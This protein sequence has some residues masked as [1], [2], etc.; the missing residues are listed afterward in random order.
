MIQNA[1]AGEPQPAD[2]R[3]RMETALRSFHDVTAVGAKRLDVE[4]RVF[5][6]GELII[7]PK[8]FHQLGQG[9]NGEA[10]R[11]PEEVD[12]ICGG[13]IAIDEAAFDRVDG[14]RLLAKPLGVLDL[15]LSLRATGGR[16]VAIPDVV[17]TDTSSLLSGALV[18]HQDHKAFIARWG[19]D[20]RTAD[21][22]AVRRRHGGSGLLWNVRFFGQAMPFAK[23]EQRPC[24]HWSNYAEFEA[25]RQ[26]ADALTAMI[27]QIT[28]SSS[29][30]AKV[31][32]LGCGDG[33]FTHLIARGGAHGIGLDPE[34]AAV[35]QAAGR[36]S[37][38]AAQGSYGGNPA[39][40]FILG[41][42]ESLPS[43]AGSIQTVAM[44]DVI[45]HLPNPVAILREV[46]RVLVPG[47]H[48]VISTP[49]WQYGESSDALYHVCEYS[50][51]EL[52]GQ[53]QAATQLKVCQTGRIGGAY[54]DLIVVARKD[55]PRR[56]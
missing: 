27:L 7:H 38:E 47:G 40:Q 53:V 36:V 43:E 32:D 19:F 24:M 51:P 2:W 54:R 50:L 48:L 49:E 12:A 14:D 18:S 23:Y 9:A 16:C 6:M 46:E 34:P 31:L 3:S 22:D 28:P 10:Y 42:G 15:F 8:G 30:P 45:E 4:G 33:L 1:T 26:R 29:P 25:Y 21:L 56:R 37:E 5:S 35:E 44:L 11:F 39:P 52:T 20:W 41:Q 55:D 17:V 13:V